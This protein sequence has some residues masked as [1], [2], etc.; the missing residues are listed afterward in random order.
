M[1]RFPKNVTFILLHRLAN[2]SYY[3]F[4]PVAAVSRVEILRGLRATQKCL[5]PKL[6]YD[7][8]GSAQF[9]AICETEAYYLTRTELG[10]LAKHAPEIHQA[11]GEDCVVVEPG[12]G[13]MSKFRLLLSHVRPSVYL[14]IDVSPHVEREGYR[15]AQ[16][17]PWMQ[18]VCARADFENGLDQVPV[19]T[20]ARRVIFFPGSTIGN[21][22]PPL[23]PD[24][25]G[26]LAR[27]AGPDGGII[28]GVDL[29]KAE[30]TLNQAYNDPE[31]HT[32][33]FNLNVL[34]R[35][36][37]EFDGNFDLCSFEHRA[38][39]NSARCRIEM[40]LLSRTEQSVIVAGEVFR[41]AR[42]ETIHTEN[43]YKYTIESMRALAAESGLQQQAV[44]TDSRQ[45][46]AEFYFTAGK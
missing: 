46:F 44:W 14:A 35:L 8:T 10:I 2:F 29:Q 42:G 36:N 43:S 18:V 38:F 12:P 20:G 7:E 32:R 9:S 25:L 16:S 5:P 39:Y 13:D 40:H 37:R 41:F 24:F 22:E 27:L 11:I 45:Y 15:L 30:T 34:A 21:M 4:S 31:G 3:D 33:E 1:L 19:P 17:Y 28:L 6:F 23:V 26:R